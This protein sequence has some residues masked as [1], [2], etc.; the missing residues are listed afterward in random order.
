MKIT[1]NSPKYGKHIILLDNKDYK[2]IEKSNGLYLNRVGKYLYARI[3]PK[4]VYLHR[5]FSGAKKGEVTDHINRNTLDNRRRN[6]RV[7]TIQ[8]NLRNQKRSNNKTGYTGV[9][10]AYDGKYS[11]QIVINYKKK[12]LGIFNTIKEALEARKKAERKYWK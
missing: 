3:K 1:V 2:E 6:L 4:K 12:H 5:L 10:I 9:A 7:G 11:A 8:D